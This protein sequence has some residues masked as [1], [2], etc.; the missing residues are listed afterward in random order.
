[1]HRQD[2]ASRK[3]PLTC[4]VY[5]KPSRVSSVAFFR[6]RGSSMGTRQASRVLAMGV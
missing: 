4:A 5:G 1:M 2:S 6:P 3:V